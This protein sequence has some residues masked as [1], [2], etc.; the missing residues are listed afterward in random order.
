MQG[1]SEDDVEEEDGGGRYVDMENHLRICP[2]I[3]MDLLGS[4]FLFRSG[5]RSGRKF[6]PSQGNGGGSGWGEEWVAT[7]MAQLLGSEEDK[8][9]KANQGASHRN[10]ANGGK[11]N[12]IDGMILTS[13]NRKRDVGRRKD[14]MA[15]G[16]LQV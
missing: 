3:E 12:A 2:R 6:R 16:N 14:P 4:A 1:G 8:Y 11:G 10:K 7:D 15:G 5:D 13:E 9:T